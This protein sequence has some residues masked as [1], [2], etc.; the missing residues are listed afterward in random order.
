MKYTLLLLI[1]FLLTY[2]CTR[3]EGMLHSGSK[4]HSSK[5]IGRVY[6]YSQNKVG[7]DPYKFGVG[8]IVKAIIENGK[9]YRPQSEIIQ[10]Y[11]GKYTIKYEWFRGIKDLSYECSSGEKE[12]HVGTYDIVA[13]IKPG[14]TYI[15]DILPTVNKY[16]DAPE[17]LCLTEEDNMAK[18]ASYPTIGT[19][20]RYPSNFANIVSCAPLSIKNRLVK[21][22]CR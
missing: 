22:K 9:V 3:T 4:A 5:E 18:G 11:P 16:L 17:Q 1:V 21:L 20:F 10:L 19:L 6:V 8:A 14:K 15:V 7:T 2:G 13:N 12:L